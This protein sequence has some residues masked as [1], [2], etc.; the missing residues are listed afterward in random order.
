MRTHARPIEVAL[1][2]S[3]NLVKMM[4]ELGAKVEF[5][6]ENDSL[7]LRAFKSEDRML[8]LKHGADPHKIVDGAP[9]FM[10]L[11]SKQFDGTPLSF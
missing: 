5:P 9:V 6:A 8:L 7:L 2:R 1:E 11:F 4:I 3:S 10:K